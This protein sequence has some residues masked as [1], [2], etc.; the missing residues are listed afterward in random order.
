[1][2]QPQYLKR[3]VRLVYWLIRRLLHL[4]LRLLWRIRVEGLKDNVPRRGGAVIAC[5]HLSYLDGL[6]LVA[7]T[8][9]PLPTMVMAELYRHW[10]LRLPLR[11]LGNIPVVRG[12]RASGLVALRGGAEITRG[13]SLFAIFPEGGLPRN[14]VSR[15]AHNGAAYIAKKARVPLI[16]AGLAGT[17]KAW[18]PHGRPRLRVTITLKF[19]QNLD[20]N[21]AKPEVIT[22]D[23]MASINELAAR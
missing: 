7:F 17:D 22:Q 5:N 1:M 23:L 12:N 8:N 9:R 2:S 21:T 11:W 15:P 4:I 6:I 20:A 10:F 18:P 3:R 16:P 13:G 14:G 19:G